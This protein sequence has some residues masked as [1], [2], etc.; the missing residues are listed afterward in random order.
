MDFKKVLLPIVGI[1]GMVIAG[2][3]L[4]KRLSEPAKTVAAIIPEA[5]EAFAGVPLSKLS[6]LAKEVYHGLKCSIDQC[7][8]LV[9][10][11]KSKRGHQIF[12]TQM[13]LDEVGKLISHGGHYPGEL[14]S[15]A[16]EFVKRANEKFTFNK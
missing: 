3:I 16:D 10:H 2:V 7:G 8:F 4:N 12:H 15:S 11:Y 1:G 14:W 13:S 5:E 9:F 6:N